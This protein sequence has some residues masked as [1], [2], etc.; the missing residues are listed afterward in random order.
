M[1][2]AAKEWLK[3]YWPPLSLRTILF[4]TLLFVAALPGVAALG[5]RVY[6]NTLVQQTEAELIAQ[7]AVL[8]AAYRSAW[9]APPE[10]R[11]PAPEPPEIDL[12][13][14]PVLPPQPDGAPAA[15]ADPRAVRAAAAIAPIVQ[16]AAA[17]TLSATRLLDARG[18]VVGGRE[19]MGRSYA[20]L[21]EVR[22]ALGGSSATVL[23]ER[24][25]EEHYGS[26]T[27]TEMLSSAAGIRVH[28][29][30]PV[31]AG[32]RVIGAV[33][34]SRSPR[35]LFLG[36]YQDRGKIVLGIVLILLTLLVIVGVLSRGIARPIRT[37][38]AASEGVALGRIEIPDPPVTAA[39]EIRELYVNF[40]AM[41][42]R[43]DTRQRY[44][45]DFAAAVSHEFK[46]PLTG[47]RGAIELL[48]EHG[49]EMS[50]AERER[51]LANADADAERLSRLVQSLLD[52]A[53]AD[54]IAVEAGARAEAAAA[55]RRV[56]RLLGDDR[57]RVTVKAPPLLPPAH[58]TEDALETVLATLIGNSR[59]AGA[60]R[61]TM[62]LAEEG[63]A[64]AIRVADD[65]PGVPE[66][67]R[68]R[69]FEPFFTGNREKGGTG[70][71]LPIARS[72]L[73]ATGGRIALDPVA[74]GACFRIV[75]A[76]APVGGSA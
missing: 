4:G 28:H 41:A 76:C 9:G 29:V 49:A 62:A 31:I 24:E 55:A 32:G 73:A 57:L 11:A 3:R 36:I 58:V 20:G 68:E 12:Q 34:V 7:S 43:I 17:V 63:G 51:F 23:R 67:D 1:I 30:R 40:A 64:L 14:N 71:G 15:P 16:D 74:K 26:V 72:L 69:I 37:L 66:A 56:A 44:L 13:S 6:E 38:A 5:L 42:E 22:R 60:T 33:M 21:P 50:P 35:G 54:M 65:G 19:D 61:V 39:N 8:A 46:T 45:Q 48:Q 52:L 53:R 25:V 18:V 70:L 2:R 47:I 27:L 10:P 59:Q 75:L